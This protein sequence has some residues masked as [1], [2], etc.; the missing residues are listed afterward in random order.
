[1]IILETPRLY[2]RELT[3]DDFDA[4]HAICSDPEVM[5]YIDALQPYSQEQTRREIQQAL[6]SYQAHGF[7][8]W[9]FIAKAAGQLI[10]YGGIQYVPHNPQ[11]PEVSY[12]L[13]QSHWGQGYATEVAAAILQYGFMHLGLEAIEASIDPHNVT[14]MHVAEKLGMQYRGEGVDAHQF[15]VVFYVIYNPHGEEARGTSRPIINDPPG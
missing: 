4:L 6:H 13:A 15:P 5:C 1:M 10:G 3:M 2:I 14:S 8:E 9:A 11:H 12:I 7:G